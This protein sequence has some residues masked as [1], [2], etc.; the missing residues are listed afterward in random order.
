MSNFSITEGF[1]GFIEEWQLSL[2]AFCNR[3][4]QYAMSSRSRLLVPP[5]NEPGQS[6]GYTISASTPTAFCQIIFAWHATPCPHESLLAVRCFGSK[7][8]STRPA[9][10]K[11]VRSYTRPICGLKMTT[12]L[13][14]RSVMI[15]T[16]C[17]VALCFLMLSSGLSAQN[18]KLRTSR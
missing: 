3:Y 18:S 8:S 5:H 15:H 16:L 1:S 9:S 12:M 11:A 14:L 2:L 4:V 13:P 17:P 7:A 6:Y 10:G